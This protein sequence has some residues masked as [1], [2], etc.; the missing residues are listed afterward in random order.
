MGSQIKPRIN[1]SRAGLVAAVL[2]AAST[3]FSLFVIEGTLRIFPG[4]LP[5]GARVRIY[6]QEVYRKDWYVPHAYIGHLHN[7]AVR[8]E[9]ETPRGVTEATTIDIGGFRNG[10]PWPEQAEIVAVGDSLTYSQFAKDNQAWTAILDRALPRSRVINLGLIGGAPQQYLRIYE[11]FGTDLSPKVL[12]VGLFLGNDLSGAMKFYQWWTAGGEGAFPE[13]G[14][15]RSRRSM[16][17]LVASSYTGAL[18]LD[19]RNS[20]Q[21]GRFFAGETIELADGGRVQLVPSEL[22][23]W[24]GAGQPGREAF[25]LVLETLE[26]IDSLA[27]Q[28]NTRC[29]VLF[30][31]MKEEVYMPLIE[32]DSPDL[33]APF[34]PELEKRGI[35]YLDLGPRFRREA[36]AGKTLFFEL[37]GH[38]NARGYALI[39]EAVL[40]YLKENAG[41]YGLKDWEGTRSR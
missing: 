8:L 34:I 30:F 33:A 36:A 5:E 23:R 24:S 20:H 14:M 7:R 1:K 13:F 31:P 17:K 18:L 11:T 26:R 35:E 9:I 27:R 16:L 22:W 37:D 21:S 41:R 2:V 4:L 38:P 3:T 28:N 12:L 15:K 25:H 32:E 39:A 29:V 6:W 40:S 19:L 10:W